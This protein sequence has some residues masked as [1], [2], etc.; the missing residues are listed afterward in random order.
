MEQRGFFEPTERDRT[1]SDLRP[2][3]T[4]GPAS[5]LPSWSRFAAALSAS[6]DLVPT[7]QDCTPA[8]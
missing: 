1:G 6:A 7:Q 8:S 2:D 5:R 4:G 3:G